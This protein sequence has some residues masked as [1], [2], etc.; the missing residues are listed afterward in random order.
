MATEL[1]EMADRWILP[2]AQES[3]DT[4]SI[5]YAVTLRFSEGIAVRIEQPFSYRSADGAQRYLV[6]EGD[7]MALAPILG[8]CRREVREGLAFKDGRLEL[9]FVDGSVLAVP[10][11]DDFEAWSLV[12]KAGL[13]FVSLPGGELAV[14]LPTTD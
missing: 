5:D 4:C 1:R 7:P 6:P 8:V 11:G 12:G 3:V 10:A 13:K 14:W 9:H 2:I